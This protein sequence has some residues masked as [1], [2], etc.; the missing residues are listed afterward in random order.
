MEADMV[1][2]LMLLHLSFS[3]ILVRV[4]LGY[5]ESWALCMLFFL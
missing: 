1:K 5:L 2:V 4:V 3:V